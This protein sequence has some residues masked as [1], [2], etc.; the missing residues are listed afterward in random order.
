VTA[1]RALLRLLAI[2]SAAIL[3]TAQPL[4]NRTPAPH[5]T[6]ATSHERDVLPPRAGDLVTR[7]QH[8]H[9][10]TLEEFFAIDDDS[11][12]YGSA[13]V[14]IAGA[15]ST[16]LV[17]LAAPRPSIR[18]RDALPSHKACAGPQTGPPIS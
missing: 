16:W 8:R 12:V 2:A 5:A 15:A 10:A 13:A 9:A 3:L 11:D 1:L 4:G 18:Y 6:V 14:R 7:K 17:L